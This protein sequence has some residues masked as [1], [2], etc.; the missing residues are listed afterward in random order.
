M[1]YLRDPPQVR[2]WKEKM[3]VQG[4]PLP[5]SKAPGV[6]FADL[7]QQ[8]LRR[9]AGKLR[10]LCVS[11]LV[12]S[13]ARWRRHGRRCAEAFLQLLEPESAH[14]QFGTVLGSRGDGRR[15]AA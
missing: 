2:H 7:L 12:R 8:I 4:V 3:R 5:V 11:G 10:G 1:A 13:P 15:S 9:I 14:I 6:L